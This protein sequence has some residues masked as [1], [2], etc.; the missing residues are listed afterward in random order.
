MTRLDSVIKRCKK[1]IQAEV[2]SRNYK[3][4]KTGPLWLEQK[5]SGKK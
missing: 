2:L 4:T 3:V 1:T 5:V